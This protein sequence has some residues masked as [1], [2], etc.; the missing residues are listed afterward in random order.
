[1]DCCGATLPGYPPCALR[2]DHQGDHEHVD[3]RCIVGVMRALSTYPANDPNK[4][5]RWV[6]CDLFAGHLGKHEVRENRVVITR[7]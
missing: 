7:F 6:R 4:G 3:G 5:I 1:M 2:A